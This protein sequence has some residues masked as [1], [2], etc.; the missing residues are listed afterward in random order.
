MRAPL[1]VKISKE[2]TF[3]GFLDNMDNKRRRSTSSI[4]DLIWCCAAKRDGSSAGCPC[5]SGPLG[6]EE[7]SWDQHWGWAFLPSYASAFRVFSANN[8]QINRRLPNTLNSLQQ[9]IAFWRPVHTDTVFLCTLAY[10]NGRRD[11]QTVR[12]ISTPW[13]QEPIFQI[14]QMLIT[15]ASAATSRAFQWRILGWGFRSS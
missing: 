2:G 9:E 6:C 8:A 11:S 15:S 7:R 13:K 3:I 4:T 1:W 12:W 10:V 14:L 5:E